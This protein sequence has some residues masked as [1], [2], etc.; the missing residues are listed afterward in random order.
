MPTG[1]HTDTA[2]AAAP[3]GAMRVADNVVMRAPGRV[4]PRPA[5][6]DVTGGTSAFGNFRDNL[7]AFD[8]VATGVGALNLRRLAVASGAPVLEGVNL[9]AV[10]SVGSQYYPLEGAGWS[11]EESKLAFYWTSRSGLWKLPTPGG[12]VIRGGMPQPAP[13][14]I[15]TNESGPATC[16]Y[17]TVYVRWDDNDVAVQSAPS[18]PSKTPPGA[19]WKL[20]QPLDPELV[21]GD[22]VEAYRSLANRIDDNLYRTVVVT[23]TTAQI[24]AGVVS[25]VDWGSA[26]RNIALYTNTALGG[27]NQSNYRPPP[28]S[29]MALYQDSMFYGN[30]RA[31]QTTITLNQ[32]QANPNIQRPG[33]R[34]FAS[35]IWDTIGL[36]TLEADV[37]NGFNLQRGM[38]L[39]HPAAQSASG[40]V[41]I[42]SVYT[43][44]AKDYIVLATALTADVGTPAVTAFDFFRV[45]S[46]TWY[47]YIS[48]GFDPTQY[49]GS[50]KSKYLAALSN[51]INQSSDTILAE[52][53]F[54]VNSATLGQATIRLRARKGDSNLTATFSPATG[55]FYDGG[56]DLGWAGERQLRNVGGPNTLV[57]SK[58]DEPEAVPL[59]NGTPVGAANYDIVALVPTRDALYVF[60]EDGLWAL[61]GPQGGGA[62]PPQWRLDVLDPTISLLTPDCAVAIGDAVYAWT[63]RGFLRI[64]RGSAQDLAQGKVD[65]QLEDMQ[66]LLTQRERATSVPGVFVSRS[67]HRDEVYVGVPT[68]LSVTEATRILVYSV[69]AD[70]WTR[71]TGF[72]ASAGGDY[73]RFAGPVFGN[74]ITGKVDYPT[75]DA[76]GAT[77]RDATVDSIIEWRGVDAGAPGAMKR[78]REVSFAFDNADD[79]TSVKLTVESSNDDASQE[80]T[81]TFTARTSDNARAVRFQV[82]RNHTRASMLY[83][84]CTIAGG[85]WI[86]SGVTVLHYPYSSRTTR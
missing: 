76:G 47:A 79:A 18:P 59:V 86:L 56:V 78:F 1:L 60:K 67:L 12:S 15:V 28:A 25:F 23:L 30:V 7:M 39:K 2:A 75:Q 52:P 22:R 70:A 45:G 65:D 32:T 13:P 43:F 24:T 26:E 57:W 5:F 64:T 73:T 36:T 34:G 77:L 46:E 84:R 81:E 53:Q 58:P 17:R 85:D 29:C 21:A 9:A 55:D 50:E 40:Y 69:R 27:I 82:P 33:Y 62:Q 80:A 19:Q 37:G 61:T 42:V 74:T 66:R 51:A 6:G 8:G 31:Y 63:T 35:G 44:D 11:S 41:E 83:P 48:P 54:L 71:W 16:V 72:S 68:N 3:P 49:S 14:V 10:A 20:I 38:L 4:E